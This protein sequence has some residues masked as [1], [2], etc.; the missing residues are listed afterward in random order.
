MTQTNNNKTAPL[1]LLYRL[2]A[3]TQP[4]GFT[5]ALAV[6]LT[7]TCGWQL[8]RYL[9]QQTHAVSQRYGQAMANMAAEQAESAMLNQDRVSLTAL[10]AD[11]TKNLDVDGATVHDVENR[12][13]VQSGHTTHPNSLYFSAPI[14]LQ[15]S[16]AGYVTVT[17]SANNARANRNRLYG[18]LA[19]TLAALL[20]LTAIASALYRSPVQPAP[21]AAPA[22][23]GPQRKV[24]LTLDLLNLEQ[25]HTELNGEAFK[26]LLERFERQLQGVIALYGGESLGLQDHRLTL[27]F[28]EEERT[29]A[30]FNAICSAE[31]LHALSEQSEL[32]LQLGARILPFDA[33]ANL[34]SQYARQ[35]KPGGMRA[36]IIS[37]KLLDE[38]LSERCQFAARAD[39]RSARVEQVLPPYKNLLENQLTQLAGLAAD[40]LS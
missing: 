35:L 36:T 1:A 17:V 8:H 30:S 4:F 15:D 24:T 25:L 14:V 23:V 21:T 28:C 13:L 27:T 33:S 10:L 11:L 34:K 12:L 7:L 26:Q 39:Q 22:V 18:R 19:L 32:A 20:A 40:T 2:A 37:V 38:S 29:D 6:L 16:V 5:L 3:R 31:L 9:D